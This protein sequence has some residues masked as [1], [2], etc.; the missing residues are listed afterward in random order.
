MMDED[1]GMHPTCPRTPVGANDPLL[2]PGGW[3]LIHWGGSGPSQQESKKFAQG[4]CHA[5]AF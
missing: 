1:D 2:F 5:V 3:L 4:A